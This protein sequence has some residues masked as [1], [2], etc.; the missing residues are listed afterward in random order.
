MFTG[1]IEETG[2]IINITDS[3]LSV[4]AEKILE[5]TGIGDSIAVNGVCLTVISIGDCSFEADLSPETFNVSTFKYLK[6]GDII[7]IH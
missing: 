4:K 3:K 1:I 5:N 2:K 7:K 6:C